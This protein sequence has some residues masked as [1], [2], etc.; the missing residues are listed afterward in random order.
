MSPLMKYIVD[1]LMMFPSIK[2]DGYD[3]LRLV[4][5]SPYL[6]GGGSPPW[7]RGTK[8]GN[9]FLHVSCTMARNNSHN[10]SKGISIKNGG[11][12]KHEGCTFFSHVL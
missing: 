4:V 12:G 7:F 11:L 10:P 3:K 9:L 1:A 2:K 6:R 8:G 5:V